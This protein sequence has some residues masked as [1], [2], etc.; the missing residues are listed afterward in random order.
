M[1]PN[2]QFSL[3]CIQLFYFSKNRTGFPSFK[4][5]FEHLIPSLVFNSDLLFYSFLSFTGLT[6]AIALSSLLLSTHATHAENA[7]HT[8]PLSHLHRH[9]Q[10][11]QCGSSALCSPRALSFLF[12][13]AVCALLFLNTHSAYP[14]LFPFTHTL[15]HGALHACVFVLFF[16]SLGLEINGERSVC[17]HFE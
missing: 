6:S 8:H 12:L 2:S 15:P 13:T 10:H 11:G 9:V 17:V 1:L 5:I 16:F 7:R 4:L 14:L 3:F